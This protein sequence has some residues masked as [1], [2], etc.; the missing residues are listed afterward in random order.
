MDAERIIEIDEGKHGPEGDLGEAVP[1]I[2]KANPSS[3]SETQLWAW[4]SLSRN[5][6]E[7]GDIYYILENTDEMVYSKIL[8]KDITIWF[9]SPAETIKFQL[10][11]HI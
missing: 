11:N 3:C 2:L 10:F 5:Y 4:R 9:K 7:P 1:G 8:D 6:T